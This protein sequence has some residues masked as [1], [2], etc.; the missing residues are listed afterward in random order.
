MKQAG[1]PSS[2]F[3]DWVSRRSG[4]RQPVTMYSPQSTIT[5]GDLYWEGGVGAV[6]SFFA[7]SAP[8]TL[9]ETAR[10]AAR[11]TETARRRLTEHLLAEAGKARFYSGGP[12]AANG[13][14]G[15]AFERVASRAVVR[16]GVF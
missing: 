16:R 5:P 10:D 12:G 8:R 3:F 2:M 15:C 14:S 7:L 1:C 6:S 4:P 9:P 13:R 11:R